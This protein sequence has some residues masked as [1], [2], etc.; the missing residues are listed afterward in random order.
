M[1]SLD[2]FVTLPA[3][4]RAGQ[5][6]H[7]DFEASLALSLQLLVYVVEELLLE[8]DQVLRLLDVVA[9]LDNLL[10]ELGNACLFL[11]RVAQVVVGL[12]SAVV[13]HE[14]LVLPRGLWIAIIILS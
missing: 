5:T 11:L 6:R 2:G 4:I 3:L 9:L 12:Q 1:P 10:G 13:V 14:R 7:A 8:L